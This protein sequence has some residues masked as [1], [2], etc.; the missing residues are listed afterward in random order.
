MTSSALPSRLEPT[1][2]STGLAS[3]YTPGLSDGFGDR[4]LMFDNTGGASLELLRFRPDLATEPGF[5]SLLRQRVQRLS[6]FRNPAFATLRAV[7]RLEDGD[8]LALV[9]THVSGRRLSELLESG[10]VSDGIHPAIVS[11]LVQQITPLVATLQGHGY[12]IVHGSLTLDRIILTTEGRVNIVEHAFGSALRGLEWS[13]ARLWR[14]LGVITRPTNRGEACLDARGDIL[15]L[16]VNA[17][18][19]LLGRQVTLQ[20]VEERVPQLLD[21][22]CGLPAARES[23]FTAPLRHWLEGALQAGLHPFGSAIDARE[24]L[25]ELPAQGLATLPELMATMEPAAP[26][27][28]DSPSPPVPIVPHE[29]EHR[30]GPD[31][32]AADVLPAAQ[33]APPPAPPLSPAEHAGPHVRAASSQTSFEPLTTADF[34]SEAV[35]TPVAPP[36]VTT[37]S[38]TATPPSTFTSE[39]TP[40]LDLA[41]LLPPEA[42][43]LNKVEPAMLEELDF[44]EMRPTLYTPPPPVS[45]QKSTPMRQW[46][47]V[48]LATLVVAEAGVI[49]WMS[50][51]RPSGAIAAAAVVPVAVAVES[52]EPGLTV[53][54]NDQPAG[55]TPLSITV[56]GSTRSIR[57]A[58]G[59]P[60]AAAAAVPAPEVG[61]PIAPRPRPGAI[62]FAS[63]VALQILEGNRV[64]GSSGDGA[65][66]LPAGTHQLELVN[67]DLGFRTR[68]VVTVRPGE[69]AS[70]TV[71]TPQGRLSLNAQPW[72]QVLVDANAVGETPIANL[73][74][75]IGQHEVTFRHPQLGEWK[76]T[77]TVRADRVTRLSTT[78]GR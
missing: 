74:V 34:S 26:R 73:A 53:F 32:L 3:W 5:E 76:E 59:I 10:R 45:S 24:G 44:D 8:A 70:F 16:G 58:A 25:K 41:T 19:L 48:G 2:P 22:F 75:S 65:I 78:F 23:L 27:L 71:T 38:V 50:I 6:T 7:E 64:L 62:Q 40:V 11:W 63:P 61:A 67:E 14:E 21:E 29:V 68:Q 35:A 1:P 42:A 77:V 49:G 47:V 33:T 57:V 56:D 72:A 15:Q 13:P 12:D 54:V 4:L 31:S 18:S 66:T 51:R 46:L 30:V 17:L 39:R 37:P 60:S 69:T 36:V 20:D 52:A 28:L 9:S 55:T 43:P